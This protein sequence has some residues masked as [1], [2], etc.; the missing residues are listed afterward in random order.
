MVAKNKDF[1]IVLDT[2]GKTS[3]LIPTIVYSKGGNDLT[4]EVVVILNKG[5]EKEVADWEKEKAA[6]IAEK[7]KAAEKK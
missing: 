2:S 3:N 5:H 1:D 7:K 6:K 4:D